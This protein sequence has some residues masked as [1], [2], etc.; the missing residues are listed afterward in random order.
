MSLL[1]IVKQSID[2]NFVKQPS[3]IY[4]ACS[5]GRDSMALLYICWQ[6]QLPIHVIHINHNIQQMSD[7]WQKLVENFC[8]TYQIPFTSYKINWQTF[9]YQK[10]HINEQFARQ[11]RYQTIANI[12][13]DQAVIALAHHADDQAETI[14][15][16]LCQ[17]TGLA[18]LAGMQALSQQTE[19]GSCLWLWRPLLAVSRDDISQFVLDN[20]IIYIDDPTNIG[21]NNRRAW[22]R[23]HIIPKLKHEFLGCVDNIARTA[24][25][26][27]DAK[28][29]VDNQA[30]IDLENCQLVPSWTMSEQKLAIDKLQ[31]LSQERCFAV[32]RLW[33]TANNKFSP[34]RQF[35][36]QV[37]DLIYQTNSEQQTILHWQG[38]H[39]RR[40]KGILYRFDRGFSEKISAFMDKTFAL[41]HIERLFSDKNIEIEKINSTDKFQRVGKDFHEPFKKICQR[42]AIPSWERSVAWV[43]WCEN[44]VIAIWLPSQ[45]IQ[46]T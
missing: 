39:I 16:N 46:L 23:Q 2:K 10:N 36:E 15:M 6:L 13:G 37:F 25:N 7:D 9:D 24:H 29:I 38:I 41:V 31:L 11:V 35:I 22:L 34:H 12:A 14:L 40:Y 44:R 33:I 5:G 18:G 28:K 20:Q 42:L 3:T 32:L 30:I 19:F 4:L 26:V 27:N 8:Q 43:V 1:N 21:E 45:I 17:G